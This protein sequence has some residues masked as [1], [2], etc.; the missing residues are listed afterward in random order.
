MADEGRY[1]IWNYW[2][3]G[4]E[5]DYVAFMLDHGSYPSDIATAIHTSVEELALR[6]PD[7]LPRQFERAAGCKV[8]DR[9]AQKSWTKAEDRAIRKYYP[10]RGAKWDG[11]PSLLG[12]RSFRAIK[13]RAHT[14]GIK[15]VGVMK[16]S[17][18]DKQ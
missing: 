14:L 11:W 9:R 12:D 15:Y 10:T 6:Y 3:Y 2:G 4:N 17:G 5:H 16:P 13:S 7:L 18:K 8:G 1:N